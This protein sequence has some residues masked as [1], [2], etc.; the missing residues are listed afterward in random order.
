MALVEKKNELF[1]SLIENKKKA[2]HCEN[3]KGRA[4]I[5]EDGFRRNP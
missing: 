4:P 1:G 5:G 2:W 3:L